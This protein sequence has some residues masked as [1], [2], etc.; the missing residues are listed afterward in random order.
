MLLVLKA[1]KV[2]KVL[3]GEDGEDGRGISNI[4]LTNDGKLV[5]SFDNGDSPVEIDLSGVLASSAT[6][7]GEIAQLKE[8]VDYQLD[9]NNPDSLQAQ[10]NKVAS[11]LADLAAQVDGLNIE[12]TFSQLQDQV[13][14]IVNFFTNSG[15]DLTDASA[16]ATKLL[17]SILAEKV[18]EFSTAYLDRT[19]TLEEFKQLLTEEIVPQAKAYFGAAK[20][21]K[22][23]LKNCYNV[24]SDDSL[25]IKQKM[26]GVLDEI[27][28][29]DEVLLEM[30]VDPET[31]ANIQTKL[32]SFKEQILDY[33]K[34]KINDFIDNLSNTLVNLYD[35]D[36]LLAMSG[37]AELLSYQAEIQSFL[38]EINYT[39]AADYAASIDAIKASVD[40]LTYRNGLS[41]LKTILNEIM[42]L[43][44]LDSLNDILPALLAAT[45]EEYYN[46]NVGKLAEYLSVEESAAVC[47]AK[48]KFVMAILRTK[49]AV[50]AIEYA[51]AAKTAIANTLMGTTLGS[52]VELLHDSIEAGNT[53]AAQDAL[54]D[55]DEELT[56]KTNNGIYAGVLLAQVEAQ[57]IANYT[58][59]FSIIYYNE[60]YART[61]D[62]LD[63]LYG[64][65]SDY[66]FD[67]YVQ[68]LT[69]IE[70]YAIMSDAA[71]VASIQSDILD[72]IQPII[73]GAVDTLYKAVYGVNYNVHEYL[74]M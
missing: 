36:E 30:G 35:L 10:I 24:V 23:I 59:R 67:N 49:S 58:S 2:L 9:A 73:K 22:T 26:S 1:H 14:D 13:N 32:Q 55:L 3:N 38:A 16:N 74:G 53:T 5:F 54:T 25:T 61:L 46:T 52:K 6:L 20:L 41:V 44:Q 45:I 56:A 50:N 57:Y 7:Q 40:T 66:I 47:K 18:E 19:Y 11:D 43:V 39:G 29:Y 31:V 21:V 34:E 69:Q 60:Y 37:S 64:K 8:K 70:V 33:A 48:D 4:E 72:I 12:D 42:D 28:A 17:E 63:E 51:S 65:S 62:P 15:V 27:R 71:T 68:P